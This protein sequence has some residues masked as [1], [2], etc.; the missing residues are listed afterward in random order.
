MAAAHFCLFSKWVLSNKF[1]LLFT[2]LTDP[3]IPLLSTF[4]SSIQFLVRCELLAQDSHPSA[5]MLM[6]IIK[7]PPPQSRIFLLNFR[8]RGISLIPIQYP[9]LYTSTQCSSEQRKPMQSSV[10]CHNLLQ[11]QTNSEALGLTGSSSSPFLTTEPIPM[12]CSPRE[13]SNKLAFCIKIIRSSTLSKMREMVSLSLHIYF[14]SQSN[15][16]RILFRPM[17]WTSWWC[18]TQVSAPHP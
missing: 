16:A 9:F 14:D 4:D 3:K 5:H 15:Q 10:F 17:F 13:P 11:E 1:L 6:C 12:P 7:L 8:E 2:L 18:Y